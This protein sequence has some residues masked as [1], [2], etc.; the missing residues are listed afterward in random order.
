M[1]SND[2]DGDDT[3]SGGGRKD[4]SRT[5]TATMNDCKKV[6]SGQ[7]SG[8]GHRNFKNDKA[9]DYIYISFWERSCRNKLARI[10]YKFWRC[11]YIVLYFYF[12]PQI[13]LY[14]S[15]EVPFLA[16]GYWW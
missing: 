16:S 13:G 10:I 6:E 15:Y 9:P 7:Q 11:F 12:P 14:F 4:S 3:G 1:G 2:K 8:R 5:V